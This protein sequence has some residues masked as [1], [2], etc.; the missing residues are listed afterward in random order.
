MEGSGALAGQPQIV[1]CIF[2]RHLSAHFAP[3]R[4]NPLD[5]D[6]GELG[7]IVPDKNISLACRDLPFDKQPHSE[8]GIHWRISAQRFNGQH[9]RKRTDACTVMLKAS[10][11]DLI[12]R[13]P[14]AAVEAYC[15]SQYWQRSGQP[16]RRTKTVGQLDARCARQP[17]HR[18]T[19]LRMR[20]PSQLTYL[21]SASI[22]AT[23]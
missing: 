12:D 17:Q 14:F 7:L 4:K 22:F 1:V 21:P 13:E 3:Y 15:V 11:K 18:P 6:L 20:H 23:R 2:G 16:V 8:F 5:V 19:Q 9:A 10:A